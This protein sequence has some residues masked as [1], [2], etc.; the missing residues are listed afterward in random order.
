[1]FEFEIMITGYTTVVAT[2]SVVITKCIGRQ[3]LK[4]MRSELSATKTR[5]LNA[6][7]EIKNIKMASSVLYGS[8]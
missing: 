2:A 3:Q 6:E 1:M 4:K 7:N 5:L 8:I